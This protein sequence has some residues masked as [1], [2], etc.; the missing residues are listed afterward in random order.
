ML[1]ERQ[2]AEYLDPQQKAAQAQVQA[3]IPAAMSGD[4]QAVHALKLLTAGNPKLGINPDIYAP[5]PDKIMAQPEIAQ[6][7]QEIDSIIQHNNWNLGPSERQVVLAKAKEAIDAAAEFGPQVQQRLKAHIEQKLSET[8]T[9]FETHG[10]D[11]LRASLG[12]L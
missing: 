5:T 1:A 7:L 8:G 2:D 9:L 4:L 10:A 3:L 12:A 6:R 11:A